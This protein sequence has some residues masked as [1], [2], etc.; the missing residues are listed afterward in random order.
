MALVAECNCL[1]R[2]SCLSRR[3]DHPP[4]QGHA[5]QQFLW[6]IIFVSEYFPTCSFVLVFFF[7]FH[8][9]NQAIPQEEIMFLFETENTSGNYVVF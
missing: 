6:V 4:K 8:A 3:K 2:S 5:D 9:E 1:G 7:L